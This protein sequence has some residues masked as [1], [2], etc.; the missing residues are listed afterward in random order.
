MTQQPASSPWVAFINCDRN[1]TNAPQDTDVFTSVRDRGAVAALLYSFTAAGCSFNTEYLDNYE[2]VI[3][4]YSTSSL[5]SART[6]RS[7]PDQ[8][9]NLALGLIDSQFVNV[10]SAAYWFDSTSLNSSYT[11]IWSQ[12]N[13]TLALLST[14]TPTATDTDAV[15]PTSF[16]V[17]EASLASTAEPDAESTAATD[18]FPNYFTKRAYRTVFEKRQATTTATPTRTS[19]DAST[20]PTTSLPAYLI[21]VLANADAVFQTNSTASGTPGNDSGSNDNGNGGGAMT[22]LAMIVLCGSRLHL[23]SG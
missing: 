23:A 4:V 1:A 19:S 13:D 22:G 18:E 7:A 9:L 10:G 2:K 14:A 16:E 21:A 11:S 6:Y 5:Q 20:R 17:P 12:L 8:R 3:D 15:E